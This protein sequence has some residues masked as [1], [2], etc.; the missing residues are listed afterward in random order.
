MTDFSI[1]QST[2]QSLNLPCDDFL[3]RKL[4]RYYELLVE[5][6]QKM[7]L[8]TITDCQEVAQKHFADSL[9]VLYTDWLYEGAH[10]IDIGTGA[11]FPAIVLKLARPDIS[12]TLLDSLRKRIDFL[13][14]VC[15]ELDIDADFYHLRAEDAARVPNLRASF[16]LVLSRAI[17]PAP[18]LLEY[19][20]PFAKMNGYVLCYKGNNAEREFE[21]ASKAVKILGGSTPQ[22]YQDQYPWGARSLVYIEKMQLTP[23][24]YPRQAGIPQKKPL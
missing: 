7:N 19:T 10:C 15:E 21:E 22:Y 2:L 14:V 18:V 16:D 8:T 3:C 9:V 13:K 12:I 11:G 6:N 24:L 20:L 4:V 17:A 1:I 23:K 5:W